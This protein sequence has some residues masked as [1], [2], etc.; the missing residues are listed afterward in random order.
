MLE[1]EINDAL[2]RIIVKLD[3]IKTNNENLFQRYLLAVEALIMVEWVQLGR[4]RVC[5]SCWGYYP[6]HGNDCLLEKALRLDKRGKNE[7]ST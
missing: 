4:Y 1:K 3:K 7:I 6:K 5:P 2:D